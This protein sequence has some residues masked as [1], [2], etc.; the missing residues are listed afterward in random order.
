M[1]KI[2]GY[3]FWIDL[4]SLKGADKRNWIICLIAFMPVMVIVLKIKLGV[5]LLKTKIR[6]I[7]KTTMNI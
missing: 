2:T 6:S 4:K 1:A 7:C 3:G 5:L